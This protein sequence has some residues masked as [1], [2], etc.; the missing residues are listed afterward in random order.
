MSGRC[1][2]TAKQSLPS[3]YSVSHRQTATVRKRIRVYSFCHCSSSSIYPNGELLG[4]PKNSS[5]S[6][7]KLG[8]K[9]D[10]QERSSEVWLPLSSTQSALASLTQL[11]DTTRLNQK[12]HFSSG[13]FCQACSGSCLW[14]FPQPTQKEKPFKENCFWAIIST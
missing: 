3:R 13:P 8:L 9:G 1:T 12:K 5:Y 10:R 6:P 7:K 11:R 4:L 2:W 14:R